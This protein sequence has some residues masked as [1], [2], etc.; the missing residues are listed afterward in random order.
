MLSEGQVQPEGPSVDV[1][2]REQRSF[3]MS[4]IRGRDTKPELLLRRGLHA[5][6]FRFRLHCAHLPGRPDLVFPK[7][8]AVI[9]VHGCFWHWHGC[10][11][12]QFPATRIAFWRKKIGDNRARDRRNLKDLAS[13]GWRILVVWECAITGPSS[14]P[15]TRTLNFCERFLRSSRKGIEEFSGDWPWAST[16][17]ASKAVDATPEV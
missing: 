10:R 15:T 17:K 7:R 9:L 8:R 1:H 2:T 3:N 14:Q 11:K 13:N 6:G 12:S 5:R 4:R 16:G